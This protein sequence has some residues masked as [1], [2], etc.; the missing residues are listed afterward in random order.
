MAHLDQPL[1]SLPKPNNVPNPP[2]SVEAPEDNL[3]EYTV[4]DAAKFADIYNLQFGDDMPIPKFPDEFDIIGGI[5]VFVFV[6]PVANII[7]LF[8]SINKL[9]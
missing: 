2:L 4:A 6:P 9:F 5:A 7:E 1:G 3:I 8:A